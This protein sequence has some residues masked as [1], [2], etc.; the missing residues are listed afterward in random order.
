MLPG[1]APLFALALCVAPLDDAAVTQANRPVL[2]DLSRLALHELVARVPRAGEPDWETDPSTGRLGLVPVLTELRRRIA[3]G[4]ALELDDWRTLLIDKGYLRWR[5]KWPISEP[6]AVSLHLPAIEQ[7][8][9]VELVPRV[10][11]W[12]SARAAHWEM[13][14]GLSEQGRRHDQ[15]YQVLGPLALDVQTIEFDLA[16]VLLTGDA[17]ARRTALG[18]TLG[19]IRIAVQPVATLDEALERRDDELSAHELRSALA[20][21]SRSEG[22]G[23]G[24]VW[25]KAKT[26]WRSLAA[27]VEAHLECGPRKYA[28]ARFGLNDAGT[29][30]AVRLDGISAE[31]LLGRR[32]PDGW[33]LHLRGVPEGVL[34]DWDAT[35]YWVGAIEIPLADLIRRSTNPR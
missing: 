12:K 6:F 21:E 14:C 11:G 13:M 28:S 23:A 2:Q 26:G 16:P 18:R 33:T 32:S 25:L 10:P 20:L 27:T 7:G 5:A 9:R 3:A 8:L 17:K 15:E 35:S 24:R 1:L 22:E 31:M 30:P 34:R 29:D 19:P 4:T